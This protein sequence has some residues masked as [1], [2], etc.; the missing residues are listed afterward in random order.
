MFQGGN[1]KAGD[2]AIKEFSEKYIVSEKLVADYFQHLTDIEI[3]KDK[4]RTENDRN[5]VERKE[6]EYNEIKREDL[7][8]ALELVNLNFIF[9]TTRSH[10]KEKKMRNK[11]TVVKVHIGGMI[12]TSFVQNSQ[13]NIHAASDSESRS[14]CD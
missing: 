11:V 13:N 2:K 6:P 14:D 10:L 8:H 9:T 3:R 1:L 5:C 12:L 4:R 7:H